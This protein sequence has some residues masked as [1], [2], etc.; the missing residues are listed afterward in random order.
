M[1]NYNYLKKLIPFMEH[2][3]PAVEGTIVREGESNLPSIITKE[4]EVVGEGASQA[5]PKESPILDAEIA[6]DE[7]TQSVMSGIDDTAS[8]WQK[9]KE[10]APYVGAAA[11]GVGLAV[12]QGG[13]D[14]P[15]TEQAKGPKSAPTTPAPESIAVP[16]SNEEQ[17][18]KAMIAQASRP[19]VT[20]RNTIPEMSNIDFG[21][22]NSIASMKQLEAVQE[23]ANLLNNLANF[24]ESSSGI[25]YDIAGIPRPA[26]VDWKAGANAMRGQAKNLTDQYKDKVAFEKED[27]NSPQSQG[28][29]A[30]AKAMG[31]NI[32][33]TASAAD[34]EKQFPQL[35]NIY[36]Q[37]E[38]QASRKDIARENREA[39]LQE[40][41]LRYAG[42]KD[43]KQAQSD[44]KRFDD[45]GKKLTSELASSRTTFGIDAKTLQGVE[46]AKGLIDGTIDPNQLNDMQVYELAKVLDRILSQGAPTI[47]GSS[48]LTPQTARGEV[49]KWTQ[50]LTNKSQGAQ[51]GSFVNVFNKTLDRESELAKNRIA[52]TQGKLLSTYADLKARNPDKWNSLLEQHNLPA[53]VLDRKMV[54]NQVSKT[55]GEKPIKQDSEVI[56]FAQKYNMTYDDA[57]KLLQKRGY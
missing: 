38:A 24:R 35:A 13:G 25:A 26:G 15:P 51:A 56:K 1:P 36:N 14:K 20:E 57:L 27:P 10:A 33:G 41:Q 17:A 11:G 49:A 29:R 50:Y 16:P 7:A 53:D 34:I 47:S 6:P 23:R 30:L 52:Q 39:R 40:M 4:G 44:T 31:F 18:M 5:I 8:K 32:T 42:M 22:G 12:S 48:K 9:L 19:S 46:N 21:Q 2:E 43:A 28:Y 45:L 3:L 55:S 54:H 37:R